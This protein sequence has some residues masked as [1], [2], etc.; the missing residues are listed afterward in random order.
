MTL[1][2]GLG[3]SS[4]MAA[5]SR[6]PGCVLPPPVQPDSGPPALPNCAK[7]SVRHRREHLG[8]KERAADRR[9]QRLEI[10]EQRR[11]ER[12]D[13]DGRGEHAEEAGG[14]RGAK[15]DEREPAG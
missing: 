5:P 14:D 8:E 6:W 1:F 12:P 10:H 13:T 2:S 4:D 15:R 9:K 11:A 7:D 3:I